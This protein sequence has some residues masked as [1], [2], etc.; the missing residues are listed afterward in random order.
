[1]VN[2]CCLLFKNDWTNPKY[3][4]LDSVYDF[5]WVE[6]L[7]AM[8]ERNITYEFT[9]Y[10]LTNIHF[11]HD[12]IINIPIL[13]NKPSTYDKLQLFQKNAIKD[14]PTVY[15]DLD[16]VI[17]NNIDQLFDIQEL[18]MVSKF[19][20]NPFAKETAP[21]NGSIIGW[22]PNKYYWIYDIW[23]NATNLPITEDQLLPPL[24]TTYSQEIISS[25]TGNEV[26]LL[27][28]DKPYTFNKK[29]IVICFNKHSKKQDY[30]QNESLWIKDY[31]Y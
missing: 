12:S 22:I 13:N 8:C 29:H 10:C 31:W 9:F 11:K 28:W 26:D 30:Y 19:C 25:Y 1:M 14:Y 24:S 7:Y 21:N 16:V 15:F 23:K 2:I 4:N 17:T 27:W 6:K 3:Q 20:R 5:S 18:T